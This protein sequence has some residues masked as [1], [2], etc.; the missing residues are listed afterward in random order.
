MALKV[1][2][3]DDKPPVS[4]KSVRDAAEH[5]ERALL[6]ALRTKIAADIDAGVPPHT[7]APLSRQIREID[8][9]IR[10][11]DQ[12]AA[13]EGDGAEAEDAAFDASA[14]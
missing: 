9:E 2:Q 5:S 14:V 7:L 12:R 1:V 13:E 3:A 6:V 10:A 4:P 8:R 11:L